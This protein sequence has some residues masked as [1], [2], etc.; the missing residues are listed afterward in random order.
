MLIL[1]L[2]ILTGIM[3]YYIHFP[4]GTQAAHLVLAAIM[5]ALQFSIVLESRK[6]I[7]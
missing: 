6:R 4:F 3:M 1:L 5:F 7:S 2:E